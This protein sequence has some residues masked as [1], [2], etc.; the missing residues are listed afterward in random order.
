MRASP[1]CSRR[2][3]ATPHRLRRI[4]ASPCAR[5]DPLLAATAEAMSCQR[6]RPHLVA[7]SGR[8]PSQ[9]ASRPATHAPVHLHPSCRSAQPE[10]TAVVL[11]ER[12]TTS[13]LCKVAARPIEVPSQRAACLPASAAHIATSHGARDVDVLAADPRPSLPSGAILRSDGRDRGADARAQCRPK[14]LSDHAPRLERG[15]PS[16]SRQVPPA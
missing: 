11:P 8:R 14:S 15:G 16:T 4:A 9:S 6:L 2:R 10:A 5:L 3:A 7:R 1:P 13:A 12:P